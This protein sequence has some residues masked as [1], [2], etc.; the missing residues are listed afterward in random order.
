MAS[1]R[2][3]PE[4]ADEREG[5]L[6]KAELLRLAREALDRRLEHR[7]KFFAALERLERLAR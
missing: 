1:R 2:S 3:E 6:T 7:E 4:S 5:E